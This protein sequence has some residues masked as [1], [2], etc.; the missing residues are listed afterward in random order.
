MN[1]KDSHRHAAASTAINMRIRHMRRVSVGRRSLNGKLSADSGRYCFRYPSAVR[2]GASETLRSPSKGE[3]ISTM[4]KIAA[5]TEAAH[6]TAAV[7][8]MPFRG[9]YRPV[10]SAITES[11]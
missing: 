6:S 7:A 2:N 4:R 1:W 3:Y 11:H 10:H 5:D 8:A 9:A